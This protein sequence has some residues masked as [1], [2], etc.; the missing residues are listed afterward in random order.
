MF[1]TLASK[2][3]M[4]NNNKSHKFLMIFIAGSL[5]YVL[6]NYYLYS[7][8]RFELLNKL[9]Q[10][11]F[12]VMALDL[13]IAYF[14]SKFSGS[15][16]SNESE[17]K[18]TN[19]EREEIER[20]LQEIKRMQMNPAELQKQKMMQQYEQ[21]QYEQQKLL[22]QY[23]QKEQLRQQQENEQEKSEKGSQQ[24][25]FM[26]REEIKE[27]EKNEKKEKRGKKEEQSK[28]K[29]TTTSSSSSSEKP[30]KKHKSKKDN[31]DEDTHIPAYMGPGP[32]Q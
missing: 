17:G 2:A 19:D 22:H 4:I 30:K 9:K 31:L 13:A 23:Q 11:F 16:S 7:G 27:S 5:A 14:L 28:K 25:P 3:P 10:Y 1:Y 20:N 18:Y 32:N 12:Y 29:T 6:L 8:E 26:T 15:S 21:H 24:S